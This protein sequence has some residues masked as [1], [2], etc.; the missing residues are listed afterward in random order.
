MNNKYNGTIDC[1]HQTIKHRGIQGLFTGYWATVYRE[2]PGWAIY[3]TSFEIINSKLLDELCLHHAISSG[4]SGAIA[5]AMSWL[6]VYPIDVAKTHIQLMPDNTN[7]TE[8]STIRVI[9]NIVQSHGWKFL[10]RGLGATMVRSFPANAVVFPVYQ[11]TIKSL[12][13]VET[14]F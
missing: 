1:I 3:F 13:S 14:F 8:K 4:V 2:I 7:A 6:L 10:F 11:Y 9:R 12:E 5:G